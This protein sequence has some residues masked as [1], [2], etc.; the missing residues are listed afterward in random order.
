[1]AARRPIDCLADVVLFPS[2]PRSIAKRLRCKAAINEVVIMSGICR[3]Q[4]QF[5]LLHGQAFTR[6]KPAKKDNPGLKSA[7]D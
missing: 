6:S 5:F 1:L 4:S 3:N 7:G 2:F